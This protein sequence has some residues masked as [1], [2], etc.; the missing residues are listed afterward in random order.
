MRR[1][2]IPS[3]AKLNW[4]LKVLGRRPD[5]Y[6]EVSTLLQ[7]IDLSDELVFEARETGSIQLDITG[8]DLPRDSRNLIWQ[9]A[10]LLSEH[11]ASPASAR[12]ILNKRIPVG[13]GLGGG[14]SNAAMTLL[15][16]NQLWSCGLSHSH[17]Q[18]LA[19]R[20]GSDVPFF[21]AGGCCLATGRGEKIQPAPDPPSTQLVLCYP[22]FP[23]SA[24]DAY[25]LGGWPTL[26][27]RRTQ[28][29]KNRA[30]TRIRRFCDYAEAGRRVNALVENDFDQPLFECFPR[31]AAVC[32]ALMETGCRPVAV[33]GSGS[34]VLGIPV[35]DQAAEVIEKL[36]RSGLG[37]VF[38]VSTLSRDQYRARLQEAGLEFQSS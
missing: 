23:I 15:A 36:E 20:L 4:I 6:H 33:C 3:F 37:Q 14:S 7:T 5:G 24:A 12:I 19:A 38:Q 21:L 29:T 13:A 10:D 18:S 28:L 26:E 35:S 1:L 8:S 11:A 25:R 31:L 2:E 22:G 27:T 16:L 30:G 9:A 17:L 32:E 34:T